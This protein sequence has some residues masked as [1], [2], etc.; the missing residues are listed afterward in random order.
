MHSFNNILIPTDFS[1]AA[2]SAV[3]FGLSLVKSVDS[4][5]TLLHVFPYLAKFDRRK[6][7]LNNADLKTVDN[8]KKQMDEFC[9]EL[10]TNSS[11]NVK[12]VLLG[13]GVEKEI[14]EFV[15]RNVFDLIIMGVN[16]NGMDNHPGSHLSHIIEKA[17]A[18]VLVIPNKL[19]SKNVPA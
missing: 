4:Q 18:P 15:E 1:P 16:S 11:V 17:N 8:I 9:K 19:V 10:E 6:G 14:L 3:Q 2:W 13:G 7:H 12:A 5:L